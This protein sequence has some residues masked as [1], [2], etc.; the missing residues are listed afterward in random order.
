MVGV[1]CVWGGVVVVVGGGG[2]FLGGARAELQEKYRDRVETPARPPRKPGRGLGA[3]I[4]QE[5]PN[6]CTP[7]HHQPAYSAPE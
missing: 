2:I 7:A 6:P 3:L 4:S 5:G 1:G